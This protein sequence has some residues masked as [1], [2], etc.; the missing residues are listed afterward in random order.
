VT[1]AMYVRV[2]A[3]SYGFIS[4]AGQSPHEYVKQ[5]KMTRY[6]IVFNQTE[7]AMRPSTTA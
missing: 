5:A 7:L 2:E 3:T 1:P 4:L 6:V